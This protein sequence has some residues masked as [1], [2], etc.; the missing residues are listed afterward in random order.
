MSSDVGVAT[1]TPDESAIAECDLAI[2][3]FEEGEPAGVV[4]VDEQTADYRGSNERISR[5]LDRMEERGLTYRAPSSEDQQPENE[6]A[7]ATT[8]VERTG[9]GLAQFLVHK[10]ERAGEDGEVRVETVGF[11]RENRE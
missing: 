7:T 10:L 2:R 6:W 11:R 9:E 4:N 1:Q 8:N 3:I 5:V